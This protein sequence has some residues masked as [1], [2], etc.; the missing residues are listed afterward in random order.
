MTDVLLKI[1]TMML[2]SGESIRDGRTGQVAMLPVLA[3]SFAGVVLR[4]LD[5][6]QPAELALCLAPGMGML[7]ISEATKEAAGYGDGWILA[8]TGVLNGLYIT[9]MMLCISLAAML[10]VF[11]MILLGGNMGKNERLPFVPFLAAAYGA[12]II[13]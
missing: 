1:V 2:L 6:A 8:A 12:V 11:I 3:A 4:T 9:L 13:R 10:L 5:G 7:M